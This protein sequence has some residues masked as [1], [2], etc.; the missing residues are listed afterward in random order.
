MKQ[1]VLILV[2]FCGVQLVAAQEPIVSPP[3]D[4]SSTATPRAS[5]IL[6]DVLW[7]IAINAHVP[8]GFESVDQP[9]KPAYKFHSPQ[10][11][12]GGTLAEALNAAVSVDERYEWRFVDDVVV[13]RPKTAWT[14]PA[15]PLNFQVRNLE[16]TNVTVGSALSRLQ[17]LIYSS[18][19]AYDGAGFADRF[20]MRV[21][22]GTVLDALNELTKSSAKVM[23][24]A[25]Y[26]RGSQRP[27][28]LSVRGPQFLSGWA[29]LKVPERGAAIDALTAT[30]LSSYQASRTVSPLPAS[31]AT[32]VPLRA[33]RGVPPPHGGP[34]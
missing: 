22:S 31:E 2:W 9:M 30:A 1:L 16:F 13:V 3:S 15:D 32:P 20:S 25:E 33:P 6:A 5:T 27:L 19:P 18:G 24:L 21:D 29:G 4:T 17:R 14:N 10:P 11:L 26:S 34:R 23:W 7:A 8:I 28:K 12:A